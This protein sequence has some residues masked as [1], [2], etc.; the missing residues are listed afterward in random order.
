MKNLHVILQIYTARRI[1]TKYKE[2]I[3]IK[4]KIKATIKYITI[5]SDATFTA[6]TA[7]TTTNTAQTYYLNQR[8]NTS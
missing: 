8:Q 4:M 7:T 6:T 1:I 3:A 2:K 5:Y